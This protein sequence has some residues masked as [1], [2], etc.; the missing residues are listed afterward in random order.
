M[1]NIAY[2]PDIDGLRAVAVVPVILFHAG[3]QWMPGGFVGVDIFFVISG[4]LISAIILREVGQGKFTFGAFYERRLRRIIPA[5]LV[6]V[7]TTV[8]AFQFF[9]LPDQA[10]GAAKSGIAALLSVS[11]IYFWSETGYFATRA[12]FMPLLHTWS[13][14]VEEQFYLL[15]PPLLLVVTRLRWN[16]RWT[17]LVGTLLAFAVSLWLSFNKPS[18]AY[19]LLPSR[20]WEL[21]LGAVLA[22]GVVPELRGKLLRELA[23]AAGLVAILF[24][25]LWVRSEMPFPGWVALLPCLGTAL[26]IHAGGRSWLASRVLSARPVVFVGLLSYSLYLWH[27]PILAGLKVYTARAHLDPAWAAAALPVIFCVSWLSWRYV[28]QP[29]RS[30]LAMPWPR[31]IQILGGGSA[32]ALAVSAVSI[33]AMGFPGRLDQ[34]ARLAL[35]AANDIDPL[36]DPCEDG[37]RTA[38]CKFGPPGSKVSYAI[39]GD[40]HAAAIRPAVEAS[41]IMG[42]AAGTLFWKPTC[43]LLDGAEIINLAGQ[44]E[45]TDFKNRM[46]REIES[47]RD[48][49]TIILV[50]RWPYQVIGTRPESGGSNRTWLVDED[51]IEPSA[52]E[53]KRVF[54]RSLKR[55]IDR[56]HE[57]NRVVII[58]GSVP[59]ASFDVPHTIAVARQMGR[60]ISMGID[61]SAAAK[62]LSEA[63]SLL[64]KVASEHPGTRF[65]RIW[66]SF[67]VKT[68][69]LTERDGVPIYSDENHLSYHGALN[70]VAPA[71][72]LAFAR[73]ESQQPAKAGPGN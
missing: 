42:P 21:G 52:E 28:E 62:R 70:V 69:C 54:V 44:A 29:F 40:S 50:G 57:L 19:Y 46:W 38:T 5:L 43:P 47:N 33:V 10:V 56:L 67:C 18:V 66:D 27:W 31:M 49:R 60:P 2:R 3:A 22:A 32:A 45:C 1:S 61:R 15:F 24:S 12:D 41:G 17:L 14:A 16:V 68:L 11:N 26:I 73:S 23:P 63:D 36:R 4:Y 48:L 64:A 20:A 7:L 9:A 53:S 13:L 25:L 6:M 35:A 51:T 8:T 34:P 30:R 59:E 58:I 37:T 39:V 55:T 72:K 71:L 65:L